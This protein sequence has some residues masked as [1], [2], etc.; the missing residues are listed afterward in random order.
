MPANRAK[1]APACVRPPISRILTEPPCP[2]EAKPSCVMTGVFPLVR[3]TRRR[4]LLFVLTGTRPRLCESIVT[5]TH[6]SHK[7]LE[8]PAVRRSEAGAPN[9]IHKQFS[10]TPVWRRDSDRVAKARRA[11]ARPRRFDA[12]ARAPRGARFGQGLALEPRR[13]TAAASADRF[14]SWTR[15][16][17]RR[18][19]R[20]RTYRLPAWSC[21]NCACPRSDT[22]GI[23]C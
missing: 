12:H 11:F 16:R 6:F 5:Q 23:L 4:A 9:A 8:R 19:R 21:R 20:L 2:G 18:W 13:L 7:C 17:P 22:R 10:S 1:P 14:G 15:D 3:A